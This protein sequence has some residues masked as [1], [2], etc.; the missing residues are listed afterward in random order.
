M[1][2]APQAA[3]PSLCYWLMSQLDDTLRP[4]LG[5]WGASLDSNLCPSQAPKEMV[6]MGPG[7]R[8]VPTDAAGP[9]RRP[10]QGP[11]TPC[12]DRILDLDRN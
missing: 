12:A 8:T 7:H 4:K 10:G 9:T 5:G 2:A 11:P 1:Q 3:G 6:A